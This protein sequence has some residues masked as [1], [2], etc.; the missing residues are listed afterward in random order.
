MRDVRQWRRFAFLMMVAGGMWLVIYGSD[1]D[2]QMRRGAWGFLIFGLT[3]VLATSAWLTW[4]RGGRFHLRPQGSDKAVES[5]NCPHCGAP[6]KVA[7]KQGL[8]T[9]Q[10]CGSSLKVTLDGVV[11]RETE[12]VYAGHEALIPSIQQLL[13]RGR[14]IEAIKLYREQTGAGLKEAKEAVEAIERGE[15]V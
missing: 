9:C 2:P 6:V 13:D 14:K 11:T 1:G 8:V 7:T 15:N 12:K 10:Y 3:I 4:Q 5:V